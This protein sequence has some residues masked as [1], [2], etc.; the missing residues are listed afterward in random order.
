MAY[1]PNDPKDKAIVEGLIADAVAEKEAEHE[2]AVAGLRNK[3]K[4]LLTKLAKA[5]AGEGGEDQTAEV[6]RLETAL[7]EAN[8]KL[9]AAEKD[10]KTSA[11]AI[12][13]LTTERDGLNTN[14]TSLL[15]DQGLTSA[16]T[17]A[18]V[19]NKFLPAVKAML[20]PK[21]ALK[22]EGDE[23]KAFVG[24]KSLGDFVKEWSQGD[25]GKAFISAANN[26]GGGV[27]G[28]QGGSG[29]GKTATRAEYDAWN[30][31]ERASFFSDGGK[32]TD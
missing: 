28:S 16:L 30:P 14:L 5:K 26:S 4:D 2:A 21:V 3:N 18:K 27:G 1:D 25:E 31:Q 13:D 19:D 32:L 8:A 29:G 20:S 7:S 6:E 10:A 15:V 24:D 23:R 17:E 22:A 11:K 9:K 12:A